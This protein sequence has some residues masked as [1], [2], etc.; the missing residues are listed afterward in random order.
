[1]V[2]AFNHAKEIWWNGIRNK[3]SRLQKL[4]VWGLPH[5][6]TQSLVSLAERSMNL[7]ATIQEQTLTLSSELG[8]I[9]IQA[10]LMSS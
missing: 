2:Y 7:Q 5:E 9:D 8:S 6:L 3:L 10:T 4:Q 1:L